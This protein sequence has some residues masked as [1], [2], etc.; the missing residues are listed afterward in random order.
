[1]TAIEFIKINDLSQA[2]FVE[3]MRIYSNA[4]PK[5]ERHKPSVIRERIEKG[6]AEL[7]VGIMEK[8][9]VFIAMLWPLK[10][11]SFILLDYMAT[12]KT[13]RSKGIGSMFI[14]EFSKVLRAKKKRLILEVEN[15]RCGSNMVER[16]RR[17]SFYKRNGLKE[18]KNVRY[19][20]P[21]L[22]GSTPTEM[23]LMISPLGERGVVDGNVIR[24]VVMQIYRELYH[25][26]NTNPL[27]K[28]FIGSIKY[29]I[30]LV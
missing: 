21:P 28:S 12:I 23:I 25:R 3:A 9:V 16:K 19:V 4:F 29:Q 15:P 22:Q 6:F 26:G 17:V 2:N 8:K 27:L 18:L 7:Y 11:T 1:M 20:L 10:G 14:Q 13:C 24:K 5:N 30:A